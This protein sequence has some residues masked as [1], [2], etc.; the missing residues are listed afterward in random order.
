MSRPLISVIIPTYNYA[1]LLIETLQSVVQQTYANWE[2]LIIDDGSA[3]E[4]P[5]VV[6]GFIQQYSDFNFRY[7]RLE[8]GGTSKAKNAGISYSNGEF[9]Q[10]LDADD[11]LSPHKLEIQV[12]L[13]ENTKYA[14]V[15]S[16]SRFFGIFG[17]KRL[18]M[19]KYP[20]GYLATRSLQDD[21]LYEK[22]TR[23]NIV[24]ISAPLVRASLVRA[25][26]GFDATL[27]N[28]E[29]W[30]FWYRIAVL[31]PHF[32]F[33]QDFRSYVDIRIHNRSA[34]NQHMHM[35]L[36]EVKVRE[37][38]NI[39]I[40]QQSELPAKEQLLKLNQDLLALHRLRSLKI[41][42]GLSYIISK[43]IAHPIA[44]FSLLRQACFKLM[45]RF[46]K[47]IVKNEH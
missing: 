42:E 45:A 29:D 27:L 40:S 34:M 36:G 28:N 9:I 33:D 11:L 38:I 41:S 47:T 26:G 8:N 22:L 2:C 35:F 21:A 6:R 4:T 25:A 3:D 20:K 10:F 1:H 32:C 43:F 16:K 23:N 13:L 46:Y 5:V 30:L 39:L 15:F 44:N 17:D 37:E 12:N 14:L 7:F 19:D 31:Q 24:T 18:I